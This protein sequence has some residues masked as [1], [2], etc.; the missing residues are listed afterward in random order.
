MIVLQDIHGHQFPC[1]VEVGPD[2]LDL[3]AVDDATGQPVYA[4]WT[5]TVQGGVSSYTT[6]SGKVNTFVQGKTINY[7]SLTGYPA[8]QVPSYEKK[9]GPLVSVHYFPPN[10]PAYFVGGIVKATLTCIPESGAVSRQ[11]QISYTQTNMQA[12]F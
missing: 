1:T 6:S 10:L 5:L 7:G 2:G 3:F 11:I 9:V 4:Y 8:G 12:G